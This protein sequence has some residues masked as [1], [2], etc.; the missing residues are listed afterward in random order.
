MAANNETGDAAHFRNGLPAEATIEDKGAFAAYYLANYSF[1]DWYGS[2][3]YEFMRT[4]SLSFQLLIF[5]TLILGSV[6]NFKDLLRK[7]SVYVTKGRN[8]CVAVSIYHVVQ[9][10]LP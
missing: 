4:T 7:C 6:K 1:Q 9:K 10:E 3:L 2:S 8:V 5:Q